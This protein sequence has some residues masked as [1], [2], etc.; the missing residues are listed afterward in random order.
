MQMQ[1]RDQVLE[2]LVVVLEAKL[3]KIRLVPFKI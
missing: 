3:P 2:Y 1:R